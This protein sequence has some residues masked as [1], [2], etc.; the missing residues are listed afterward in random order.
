MTFDPD[1]PGESRREPE[2]E[3]VVKMALETCWKVIRVEWEGEEGGGGRGGGG[4]GGGG[5]DLDG[6]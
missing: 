6:S 1:E 3:I 5:N 2:R 4:G